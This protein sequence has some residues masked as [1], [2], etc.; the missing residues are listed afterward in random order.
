MQT[1]ALGLCLGLS[2]L[3]AGVVSVTD[4]VS[5]SIPD[6]DV[7]GTLVKLNVADVPPGQGIRD[8]NVILSIEG[9]MGFNG[10][11]YAY[12]AKSGDSAFSILLNRPGRDANDPFGSAGSGLQRLVFDDEAANGDIHF[13]EDVTGASAI[14]GLPWTGV[15]QPDG[16]LVDPALVSGS[17]P[18]PALLNQFDGIDPNGDWIL[19]LADVSP[20]GLLT[21]TDW[22]LEFDVD[23]DV[24][25]F[26]GVASDGLVAGGTVFFDGNLNGQLDPGEP[27]V[28]TDGNGDYALNVLPG[29]FDRNN[30]NQL[31]VDE[32]LLV[33]TGGTD[34]A[35]GLP[36]EI[37][38][39]APVGA[40]VIHPLTSLIAEL[41]LQDPNIT[42]PEAES[43]LEAALGL[44]V[45][46][47]A[48][49]DLYTFDI[50]A[51]VALENPDAV[52]LLNAVAQ[53]QDTAFQVAGLMSGLNGNGGNRSAIMQSVFGLLATDILAGKSLDLTSKARVQELLDAVNVPLGGALTDQQRDAAVEI[54]V[55][56]NRLKQGYATSSETVE[57]RVTQIIQTQVQVQ[58]EIV[59][60]L[61]AMGSGTLNLQDAQ[62]KNTFSTLEQ[63][64]AEAPVGGV[65]GSL[66]EVGVFSFDLPEYELQEDGSGLQPITIIRESGNA[67]TVNLLVTP[68]R[69]TA[70]ATDFVDN[71]IEVTFAPL[72]IRH[73]IDAAA[74]LIDDQIDEGGETMGLSL[75]LRA[76]NPQ[77]AQLGNQ[78]VAQLTIIDDDH[79]GSVS[80]SADRFEF[81]ENGDPINPL[82]LVRSEGSSGTLPVILRLEAVAGGATAGQDFVAEDISVTFEDGNLT[83]VV[84]VSILDDLAFEPDEEIGLTLLL[85][86]QAPPGAGLGSITT[87]TLVIRDDD[88]NHP[89]TISQISDRQIFED[90][91]L[92]ALPFTVG[93]FEHDLNQLQVT[94]TSSNGFLVPT[95]AIS[96][97]GQGAN[98]SISIVPSSDASGTTTITVRVSDGF[99]A[100]TMS[101]SVTVLPVNDPPGVFFVPPLTA[102][103]GGGTVQT[104][105]S[106]SDIDTAPSEVSVTATS[107]N[108]LLLPDSAIEVIGNSTT[109]TIRLTPPFSEG[110]L[111]GIL[112]TVNDGGS[113]STFS[114]S[115]TILPKQ[116]S[117]VA[118]PSVVIPEDGETTI[119][120]EVGLDGVNLSEVSFSLSG[121]NDSLMLPAN[122]QLELLG[123]GLQ[124]SLRPESDQN[125]QVTLSLTATDGDALATI[126]IAV[127]VTPVDDAPRVSEIGNIVFPEDTPTTVTVTVS[128]VDS[129]VDTVE[130][131]ELQ[132]SPE[133]VLPLAGVAVSRT[134]EGFNLELNPAENQSG[135]GTL[136][137]VV[138]DGTSNVPLSFGFTVSEVNDPPEIVVPDRVVLAED[139]VSAIVVSIGDVETSAGD[140]TLEIEA[141]DK[142]LFPEGS[143]ILQGAGE[144]RTLE[145]R[146]ANERGGETALVFR[147]SDGELTTEIQTVVVVETV[148]DP[149]S[150]G[151]VND[152]RGLEDSV[153]I[154]E[155][156]FSDPD[157]EVEELVFR[158]E[159]SDTNLFP[160]G[161]IEVNAADTAGRITLRPAANQFG[162]AKVKLTVADAVSS[163]SREFEVIVEAVDDPLVIEPIAD[164]TLQSGDQ[165][166]VPV[167]FSDPD[168]DLDRI[169]VALASTNP[170]LLL[171]R[172]IEVRGTGGE[173]EFDLQ[174]AEG[175]TGEGEVIVGVLDRTSITTIRFKVTVD[176]GPL[177]VIQALRWELIDQRLY[178]SWDGAGVL[179]QSDQI[180]RGFVPL[181]AAVSPFEVQ[182]S[183]S[184]RSFFILRAP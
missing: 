49:V 162:S 143:L 100:T 72:Q 168:A 102:R 133:N 141:L 180:D 147:L 53:I 110:G 126:P 113:S 36:L 164:M 8:L 57:A 96:L 66:R 181:P 17:E 64:V 56:N 136:S 153:Q 151:A 5:V 172:G 23:T 16:R 176:A 41:L 104:E 134:D 46:L 59:T 90:G 137:L 86:P 67:G 39:R 24:T 122:Q 19:F 89:P 170:S 107:T 50:F 76:G 135:V 43:R 25:P 31:S 112:L 145:M 12:L 120:I 58:S 160:A 156:A 15:W 63:A 124:L 34:I 14:F 48:R 91:R 97:G 175:L 6:G 157:T 167:R 40:T 106:F 149:P 116:I 115:L 150:L 94:T 73:T 79:V 82:T 68:S 33:L 154:V 138:T 128:D 38:F 103:A 13:Y 80:L 54:I 45:Q 4:E 169:Q 174:I 77:G 3:S 1:V 114:F 105:V 119:P 140:L 95:T 129:A 146:P 166:L 152:T 131:V 10:D 148:D 139:A 118:A 121:N 29:P 178:I 161:A 37:P 20:G 93:D 158:T 171:V 183:G 55:A 18:R 130:I 61:A 155:F 52:V 35:T 83:Q 108:Q 9:S 98:R 42:L 2:S 22:T 60:D 69:G 71:A 30:D 47:A 84:E 179:H 85:A 142:T 21:L 125:G 28:L 101:F 81:R 173:R 144:A 32:G 78:T 27:W 51:E 184:A 111:V 127:E 11:L 7:A 163:V 165:V 62:S 87:G 26:V 65:S 123:Q 92:T 109:R 88:T 177:P 70:D 182:T 44:D 159:S 75:G 74:L 117:L 132:V 99:D